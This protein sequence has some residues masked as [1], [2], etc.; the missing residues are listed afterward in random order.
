MRENNQLKKE[1]KLEKGE[2]AASPL[3]D[4]IQ[5]H[6]KRL[7]EK[8]GYLERKVEEESKRLAQEQKILK[9]IAETRRR[10]ERERH[11]GFPQPVC[12]RIG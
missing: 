8:P 1:L 6:R 11:G 12:G 5:A 10:D 3:D 4:K 9:L 2:E 7:E